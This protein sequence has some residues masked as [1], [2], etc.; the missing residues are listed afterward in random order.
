MA[1]KNQDQENAPEQTPDADETTP[2]GDTSGQ[3]QADHTE[4][5]EGAPEETVKAVE[6]AEEKGFIGGGTEKADY[7]QGNPDVMNGGK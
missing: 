1:R 7:S 4:N 6:E 3:P 5:Q 2:V